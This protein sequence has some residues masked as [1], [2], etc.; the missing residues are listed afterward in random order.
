MFNPVDYAINHSR[1][2]IA[3][4]LFFTYDDGGD[5]PST[6]QRTQRK[7]LRTACRSRW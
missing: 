5:K 2:T 3:T 4:L 7:S 1:L 6:Q